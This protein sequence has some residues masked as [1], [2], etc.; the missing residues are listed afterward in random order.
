MNLKSQLNIY[1]IK[2]VFILVKIVHQLQVVY[3]V[4]LCPIEQV[5]QYALVYLIIM[6]LE[7]HV[8]FVITNVQI[9]LLVPQIVPL[10]Q[11]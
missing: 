1:F 8:L 10:V 7:V 5:P 11:M 4:L 9:V 6:K 2:Y 3:P